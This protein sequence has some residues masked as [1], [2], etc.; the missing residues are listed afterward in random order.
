MG[1]LSTGYSWGSFHL[2]YE[3]LEGHHRRDGE[4]NH[5]GNEVGGGFLKSVRDELR[6]DHPD[7][8]SPRKPKADGQKR[9]EI[10]TKRNAGIAIRGWGTLE[11]MLQRTARPTPTPRGTRT[12]LIASPSGML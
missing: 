1:E 12:R 9:L 4:R 5:D 2:S 6:E 7:H 10:S 3:E 8:R 11:K